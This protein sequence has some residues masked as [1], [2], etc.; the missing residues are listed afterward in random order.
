[1][2]QCMVCNKE[3]DKPLLYCPFDGQLLVARKERDKLLGIILDGKFRLDEKIGEGG[4]GKVYKAKHIHVDHTV[5]IKV[6]HPELSS[7]KVALER[8]RREAQAAIY[9]R[10]PNAV[11]VT[12]F[13]VTQDKAIAYLVMEFLEGVELRERINQQKQLDFH[14]AFLV[15]QQTCAALH[16]A[17][18][19]GIVHRDLKPDNIWL[20]KSEDGTRQVKVLDFGIAK[21]KASA[22]LGSL[23][24]QGMVIGTPYYM[25]PEQ[26]R[27]EEL[28]G[29]S[30]IYSLGV[31]LY[32][33][34]TG[35]LPFQDSSSM[36]V[37]IKHVVEAP[38][39]PRDLRP[40][41]PEAIEIVLLRTLN[42]RREDRQQSARQLSREFEKALGLAGIQAEPIR[43]KTPES[44]FHHSVLP[45]RT[46]GEHLSP[47]PSQA[48]E[49]RPVELVT[50]ISSNTVQPRDSSSDG[51]ASSLERKQVRTASE[52]WRA[53]KGQAADA[54]KRQPTPS[55]PGFSIGRMTVN[56]AGLLT[57][58]KRNLF[59][60]VASV[61]LCLAVIAG[62]KMSAPIKTTSDSASKKMLPPTPPEGM[63]YVEGGTFKMGSD[64][65]NADPA[66]TPS[67]KVTVLAF[68]LD[69]AEVTNEQYQEFVDKTG[70]AAPSH[71]KNNKY[72]PLTNKF[73]VYNVSWDDA[74]KYARWIGKRLPTEEEWEYAARGAEGTIYPWGNEAWS[75]DK[76]N[77]RETEIGLAPVEYFPA[78][79]SWCGIKD[80]VGNVAEWVADS[81]APYKGGSVKGVPQSKVYRGGS[82]KDPKDEFLT[83]RRR[84]SNA[85]SK[86]PEIGFRCAKDLSK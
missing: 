45:R 80:L 47:R 40:D 9:V 84:Y 50:D 43:I 76:A 53:L 85:S 17:H 63:K 60:I 28:D 25:S 82:Y 72:P 41:I 69:I 26:C 16:A 23:T 59:I 24:Q 65:L 7:D 33:M 71:W 68:F 19:K 32:E 75:K 10:H 42:K 79:Q 6:L 74:N 67:H 30:D 73:P 83:T 51:N 49:A 21:L 56:M 38:R 52:S 35:E 57:G 64:A 13:G 15:I 34:L 22:D 86:R 54:P 2:K 27:G 78:G 48:S 81:F 77:L 39:P 29:R 18:A 37:V 61:I 62:I 14:E 46:S 3:F 70:Y 8:F 58:E 11:A 66:F 44:G 12:D 31:I 36:A 55:E 1:M 5:A 4:M 20:V